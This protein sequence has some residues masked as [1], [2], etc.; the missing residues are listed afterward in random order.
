V[1]L[2]A[3]LPVVAAGLTA[4]SGAR[5]APADKAPEGFAGVLSR[6]AEEPTGGPAGEPP[7]VGG[8]ANQSKRHGGGPVAALEAVASEEPVD[9][10]PASGPPA[11]AV[12]FPPSAALPGVEHVAIPD[13]AAATEGGTPPPT[14][15]AGPS[16]VPPALPGQ[17]VAPE[18]APVQPPNSGAGEASLA[19]RVRPGATALAV[20]ETVPAAPGAVEAVTAGAVRNRASVVAELPNAPTLSTGVAVDEAAGVASRV[21]AQSVPSTAEAAALPRAEAPPPDIPIAAQDG[22][23]RIVGNAQ[24]T[25][26]A[27]RPAAETAALDAGDA[28]SP[29]LARAGGAATGEASTSGEGSP[30]QP[31]GPVPAATVETEAP[32]VTVTAP[33][34]VDAPDAAA[35][36]PATVRVEPNPAASVSATPAEPA[37][38]QETALAP[39]QATNVGR[40]VPDPAVAT[41]TIAPRDGVPQTTAPAQ[42]DQ[43]A[44]AVIERLL[45]DGGRV[46]VRLDPPELGEVTLRLT[47]SGDRVTL[48]AVVERPGAQAVLRESQELLSR[49]L[50]ERGLALSDVF[51]GLQQGQT[52][53][54]GSQ[55]QASAANSN[56]AREFAGLLN[57]GE[58]DQETHSQH[59]ALRAAYNPDGSLLYRV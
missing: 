57:G 59:A 38:V 46:T 52:Q 12:T 22:V 42:I 25:S 1:G 2:T 26:A 24:G 18:R 55:R 17:P 39:A 48:E 36:Q 3:S 4:V 11:L 21:P 8:A 34:P 33:A 30:R 56:G 58:D 49:L 5:S 54:G 40:P 28:Y 16:G 15:E 45:P 47:I 13:N 14:Q 35:N 20:F 37:P 53:G 32:T 29:T 44:Q 19:Q 23:V 41:P 43:V 10:P 9:G 7:A 51:V 50:G 27:T 31:S 6:T